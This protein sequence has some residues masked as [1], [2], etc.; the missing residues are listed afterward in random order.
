MLSDIGLMKGIG[1]KMDWL[2][3]RQTILSQN[4]ANSDTPN[5]RPRDLKE[6][7]FGA[8]MKAEQSK[9][10]L[11]QAATNESHIGGATELR[12]PK[13]AKSREVYEASIDGNAV[14]L[15]EQLLKAQATQSDYSLVT[16]LYKK[17]V[18]MLRMV[19]S[20]Q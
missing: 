16:N 13:S 15:E 8:V 10:K 14:V 9:P 6:Q 12:A 5:Y 3:Q 17:N 2:T 20:G 1:G 19:V 7:D 18:G 11:R 4:I